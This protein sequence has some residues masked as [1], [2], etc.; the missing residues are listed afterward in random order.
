MSIGGLKCWMLHQ[1]KSGFQQFARPL[2]SLV[3]RRPTEGAQVFLLLSLSSWRPV[4]RD[5]VH[6]T[7][8]ARNRVDHFDIY[9]DPA[10]STL[11]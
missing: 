6:D 7:G 11:I 5:P 4:D 3:P 2:P 9:G 8:G 1:R 10:V